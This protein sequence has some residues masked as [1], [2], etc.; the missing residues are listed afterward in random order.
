MSEK[1][2]KIFSMVAPGTPLHE[3]LENILRARTGG[4]VV[5]GDVPEV[6]SIVRGGFR[7][8]A[9]FSP[10][11]MYELAKMDGAIILSSSGDRI[12]WANATLVP[13]PDI[14][15]RETGLRHSTAERVAKMTG[16]LVIAISQRRSVIT[17]YMGHT[18]YVLRDI[19][20]VLAKANQALQTMSNY[21][22]VFSRALLNLSALEF[23][24][25]VTV[26]DIVKVIQR[27]ELLRRAWDEVTDYVAELGS[28]GRLVKVQSEEIISG[29]YEDALF[30]VMDYLP[31]GGQAEAEKLLN[32]LAEWPFDEVLD[33]QAVAKA[34]TQNSAVSTESSM[35]PRGY[36]ALSKI[37]RLPLSVIQ[38]V[39]NGFGSL[40]AIRGAS[41]EELDEI[42]GIGEVRARAVREG[43]A[44]LRDQV[45]R[46]LTL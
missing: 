34:L 31:A 25:E 23:I 12:V 39:V 2:R 6:I 33:A 1:S 20:V 37:S 24:E 40:K 29:T 35:M 4:F 18:R 46:N 30:V 5:V 32:S 22:D 10:A 7:L 43:L 28:E 41:T 14:P 45:V 42:D 8:D 11:A 15:S 38:N 9:E 19:G 16:Q 44:R 17:V 26:G 21:Q 36:R 3:G 27:Y 13:D